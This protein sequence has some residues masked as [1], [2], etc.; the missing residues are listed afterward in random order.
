M[1]G[2]SEEATGVRTVVAP[3]TVDERAI[4][5]RPAPAAPIAGRYQ[6]ARRLGKGGMGEVMLARDEQVG[7]DVA[8]KRMRAADPTER[9]VQRFLREASIQ[10]RLE[11]PAIVPVHEIGKDTDGLPF[12][13]MKKLAGITLSKILEDQQNARD[14]QSEIG[15][16]SRFSL[17]RILRAFVEVCLA[18]EF[19][20][21][22]GVVHRDLKPDNIMLG[23]FGEV[24]VLD[25][26]VAKIA[27]EHDDDFT[28][29]DSSGGSGENATIVG[30][31]IG[32]PGYMAPEQIRGGEIDG[33][34]DVYTL[35]CLLFEILAAEP[36]HP[37][38]YDGMQSALFRSGEM[39]SARA[40]TRD[41]PPELDLLCAQATHAEPELR[42]QTA[43]EL[44]DRVQQFLDGD[45][46]LATRRTLAKQHLD[47]AREAFSES[48][49]NDDQ[50]HRSTAMREAAG[51]LA[52]DPAQPGAAELMGRLML[53]PPKKLPRE[54]EN[55]I[56]EDNVRAARI[57]AK[58]G[59]LAVVGGLALTP[60]L[61]WVAP[62]GSPWV[63]ALTIVMI[64]MGGV[65]IYNLKASQP[66]TGLVVV[67]NAVIIGM[68]ACGYSPLLI[69]PG[70]AAV[71]TMAMVFTP[72]FSVFGSGFSVAASAILAVFGP[73]FLELAG[74]LDASARFDEH[75]VVFKAPAVAATTTPLIVTY[76]VYCFV[77]IIGAAWIAEMM[78][79]RTRDA[80]K[81]LQLQAWQLKQIVT[82]S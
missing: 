43:R 19:A 38:G 45:R 60:L 25:W 2:S 18:V 55:A 81:H 52:L 16:S 13:A 41:I 79:T 28:D 74:V 10:G 9:Q 44:G 20:H 69:A 14:S 17:Q 6:V 54:V 33:R 42:L 7:R 8:I 48:I 36:L 40:T 3:G 80:H 35:G 58:G 23:D 65:S 24:Y 67:G 59:L 31:T 32:T 21:V 66:L 78:R 62:A 68:I 71:L 63:I 34:T 53:E 37:R 5:E 77:L 75:G 49:A 64:V 29:V 82:S 4:V 1:S 73:L 61:W 39:P 76:G 27:G 12:F 57:N 22:R 47:R 46:D 51:A 56:T 15:K 11:H 72:R 26:G 30:T 70:L 50:S